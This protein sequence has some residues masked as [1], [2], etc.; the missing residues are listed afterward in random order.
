VPDT[1]E[2][3]GRG[4]GEAGGGGVCVGGG[5]PPPPGGG[6]AAEAGEGAPRAGGAGTLVGA[7]VFALTVTRPQSSCRAPAATTAY[8]PAVTDRPGRNPAGETP[9]RI[10]LSLGGTS[11]PAP[12]SRTG[13]AGDAIAWR[14][15]T[16]GGCHSAWIR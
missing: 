3:G 16:Q 6:G 7:Y 15:W 8:F 5:G 4:G 14:W 1:G 11:H 9:G 10:P 2:K 12:A 13:W